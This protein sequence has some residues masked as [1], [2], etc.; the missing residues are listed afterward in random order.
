[1]VFSIEKFG[2]KSFTNL[3]P[4]I[5]SELFNW[6]ITSASLFNIKKSL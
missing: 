4:L 3:Y 2:S 5:I 6:V 1:M